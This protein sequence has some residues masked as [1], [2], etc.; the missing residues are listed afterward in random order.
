MN[1]R[2]RQDRLIRMYQTMTNLQQEML[3]FLLHDTEEDPEALPAPHQNP[4]QEVPLNGNGNGN[5][6]PQDSFIT[7]PPALANRIRALAPTPEEKQI[8]G[9][10]LPLT[11][12]FRKRVERAHAQIGRVKFQQMTGMSSG[13]LTN[14]ESGQNKFVLAGTKARLERA[15]QELG[16]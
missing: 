4:L 14:L 9:K 13:G 11:D 15:L 12:A 10:R 7:P 3:V 5:H 8:K 16:F 1:R 6:E 2:E